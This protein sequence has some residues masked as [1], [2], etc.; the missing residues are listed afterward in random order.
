MIWR[1]HAGNIDTNI[2]TGMPK[3]GLKS[4]ANMT[5]AILLAVGRP[6]GRARLVASDRHQYSED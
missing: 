6:S 3:S 2:S 5:H 1:F 4:P